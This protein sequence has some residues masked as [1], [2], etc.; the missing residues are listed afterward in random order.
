MNDQPTNRE[1]M[2]ELRHYS[3]HLKNLTKEVQKNTEYRLKQEGVI[4]V[5]KWVGWGNLML[6][7]GLIIEFFVNK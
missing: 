3:N 6:N 4:A 5:L 7:V 2:N 1:I